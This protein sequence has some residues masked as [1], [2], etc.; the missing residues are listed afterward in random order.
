VRY[1]KRM[2]AVTEGEFVVFLIGMRI[3]KWWKIHRWLPIV[4]QMTGMLKELYKAPELGLMHHEQWFGR[5]TMM[6]QYWESLDQL[7][8]YAKNTTNTHLPAWQKF[9]RLIASNGDVGIWH[10]TY[11][12]GKG[13]YESVYVNMPAFGLG[14]AFKL[15]EAEGKYR[16]SEERLKA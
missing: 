9:N 15:V 5:T 10:E 8:A 11:L 6:V 2:T 14:K 4:F 3:N 13:R 12:S 1:D 7:E 16:S